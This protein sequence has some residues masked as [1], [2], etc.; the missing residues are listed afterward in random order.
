MLSSLLTSTGLSRWSPWATTDDEQPAATP[1]E[2]PGAGSP[3]APEEGPSEEAAAPWL[4]LTD[5]RSALEG[6]RSSVDAVRLTLQA[7]CPRAHE[8]TVCD[9]LPPVADPLAP[10]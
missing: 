7:P 9:P 3:D 6:H 5:L 10:A 2:E 1:S 8:G 4:D